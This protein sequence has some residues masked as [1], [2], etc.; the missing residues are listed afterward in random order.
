[1]KLQK[2][3]KPIRP[4]WGEIGFCG[5]DKCRPIRKWEHTKPVPL[6]GT[7]DFGKQNI[8]KYELYE[9]GGKMILWENKKIKWSHRLTKWVLSFMHDNVK[10]KVWPKCLEIC[11]YQTHAAQWNSS[12]ESCQNVRS[13]AGAVRQKSVMP[14]K[15]GQGVAPWERRILILVFYLV[16]TNCSLL[17]SFQLKVMG[18][19]VSSTGLLP[20]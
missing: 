6:W 9:G 10:T 14:S 2:L 8:M 18:R 5:K 11:N 3:S 13:G 16:P 20:N 7:I 19:S 17:C 15:T 12:S 4:G 1:M